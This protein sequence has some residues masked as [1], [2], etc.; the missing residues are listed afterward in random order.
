MSSTATRQGRTWLAA[1]TAALVLGIAAPRPGAALAQLADIG[2]ADDPFAPLVGAV[3]LVA[4]AAALWLAVSVLVTVVGQ[5]PGRTG[6]TGR[7]L[8]RRLVPAAVHRTLQ[9]SLGLTVAVSALGATSASA[10]V[11]T[12]PAP[13]SWAAA[14]SAP[15]PVVASLDWPTT[16]AVPPTPSLSAGA[17]GAAPAA[18]AATPSPAASPSSTPAVPPVPAATPSARPPV[19]AVQVAAAEPDDSGPDLAT[20][21]TAR[22]RSTSTAATSD[23]SVLVKTGDS[24]WTISRAHLESGGETATPADVARA[25]PQW[26]EA[27]RQLVG[28]DPDLVFPGTQ[29]SAPP[30]DR[31]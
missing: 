12:A 2:A 27:N 4:W 25:W 30:A 13:T 24:L 22:D 20:A 10:G 31:S 8:S 19:A 28:D 15:D 23:R 9:L 7:A 14:P 6:R 21:P 1:A 29:L 18:P 3:S 5:C 16:G 26:W 17:P 11:P